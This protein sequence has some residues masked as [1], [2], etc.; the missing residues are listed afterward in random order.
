MVSEI[1]SVYTFVQFFDGLLVHP[2]G[3]ASIFNCVLDH[4]VSQSVP[5]LFQ[6]VFT[7][8]FIGSGMQFVVALAHL[9]SYIVGLPVGVA[10]M[11]YTNLRVQGDVFVQ[12]IIKSKSKY[13]H[14]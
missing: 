10:L 7:G 2:R 4:G 14:I 13:A 3:A 11:F 12:V 9:L 1:L 6:C 5:L 8:I